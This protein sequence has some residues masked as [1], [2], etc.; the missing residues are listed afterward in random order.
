M[1]QE[2]FL[3]GFD[4]KLILAEI[5]STLGIDKKKIALSAAGAPP[6]PQEQGLEQGPAPQGGPDEMSQVPQPGAGA[7]GLASIFGAGGGPQPA[8]GQVGG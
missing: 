3:G 7:G 1:F 4:P 2:A 8:G 5:I 6:P